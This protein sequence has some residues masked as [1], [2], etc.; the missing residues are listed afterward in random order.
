ML[1]RFTTIST[2][3]PWHFLQ[4]RKIRPKMHMEFQ[5]NQNSQN[6]LYKKKRT[7]MEDLTFTDFKTYCKATQFKIVCHCYK[8]RNTDQWNELGAQK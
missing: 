6:E 3:F 5:K 7:Q 4:N 2:E 1:Y 8:G